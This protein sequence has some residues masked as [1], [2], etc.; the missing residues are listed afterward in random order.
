MKSIQE[1]KASDASTVIAGRQVVVLISLRCIDF[2]TE[3]P[4]T[5]L[6][7]LWERACSRMRCVIH[8]QCCLTH[9]FREQARSHILTESVL[10]FVGNPVLA[11]ANGD[12]AMGRLQPR[13]EQATGRIAA[14]ELFQQV[15][16]KV[17]N[18]LFQACLLYTS[19]A[20]DE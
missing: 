1:S 13:S 5:T 16:F 8:H 6:I 17:A 15:L 14:V 3:N 10:R 7:P 18:G 2:Q 11:Q 20:A 19:D 4:A 12:G 9:R